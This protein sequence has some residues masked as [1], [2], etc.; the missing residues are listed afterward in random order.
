M[1]FKNS[2]EDGDETVKNS[3]EDGAETVKIHMKMAM[4]Q[5]K[6]T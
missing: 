2:H 1:T 4:K 5:S 6:F 3:H